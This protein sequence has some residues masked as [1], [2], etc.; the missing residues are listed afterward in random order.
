MDCHYV[1]LRNINI[2]GFLFG[3]LVLNHRIA[4]FNVLHCTNT[5]VF[6][7]LQYVVVQP[8]YLWS[9]CLA[10]Y[11]Y[12]VGTIDAVYVLSVLLASCT[13]GVLAP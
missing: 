12:N 5:H 13:I 11:M 4:K 2:G 3:D 8:G 6:L 9:I 10:T 1:R 7:R